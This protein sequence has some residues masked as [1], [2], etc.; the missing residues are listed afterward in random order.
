MQ[1]T[2]NFEVTSDD[3]RS[4]QEIVSFGL[5]IPGCND[6]VSCC[7]GRDEIALMP[8]PEHWQGRYGLETVRTAAS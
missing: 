7:H 3:H 6:S 8:M 1:A 5:L 4:L 2:R